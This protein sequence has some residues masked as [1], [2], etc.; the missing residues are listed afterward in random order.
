MCLYVDQVFVEVREGR[1]RAEDRNVGRSR[2]RKKKKRTP[3][4]N[5][6]VSLFSRWKGT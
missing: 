2:E 5:L 6:H 3:P 1:R 4:L